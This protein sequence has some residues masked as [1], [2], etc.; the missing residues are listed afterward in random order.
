MGDILGIAASG[1]RA[2]SAGIEVVGENIARAGAPGRAR[3]QVALEPGLAA[4][5]WGGGVEVTGVRRLADDFAIA[6]DRRAAADLARSTARRDA[7]EPASTALPLDERGIGAA[8]DRLGQAGIELAADPASVPLARQL[9]DRGAEVR[10]RLAAAATALDARLAAIDAGIAGR[11][12]EVAADTDALAGVDAALR[13]ARPGT[14]AHA[15]LLDARD[16]LLDR[17][18]AGPGALE[19]LAAARETVASARAALGALDADVAA[20]LD[21][22]PPG[23]T[24]D[25][26]ERYD[27]IATGVARALAGARDR[28]AADATMRDAAASAREAVG[29]VDLDEEAAE[30]L[31]FQQAWQASARVIETARAMFDAILAAT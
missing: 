15:D 5:Q 23:A 16:A 3:R 18:A 9:A 24:A 25:L 1:L 12:A 19:G 2:A 14:P 6:E 8:L 30:M 10:D 11:S 29:A 28:A 13:R 22:G 4:G 7:L 31:R 20:R 26:A 21:P 27:A 17:L